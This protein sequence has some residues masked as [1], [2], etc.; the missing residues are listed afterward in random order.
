MSPCPS[1]RPPP[2]PG[3]GILAPAA[4]LRG[5]G[6]VKGRFCKRPAAAPRWSGARGLPAPGTA[7]KKAEFNPNRGPV[8]MAALG[9][10][11]GCCRG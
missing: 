8:A 3:A 4:C 5:A 1:S 9:A 2:V 11:S 6:R 7:R 10:A